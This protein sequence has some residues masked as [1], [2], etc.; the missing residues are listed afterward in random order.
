MGTT[1]QAGA[2][3]TPAMCLHMGT[4]KGAMVFLHRPAF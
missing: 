3:N 4:K 2:I 1:K